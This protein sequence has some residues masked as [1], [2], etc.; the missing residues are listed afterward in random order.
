MKV[1]YHIIKVTK[2]TSSAC[3][4]TTTGSITNGTGT[5]QSET[6]GDSMGEISVYSNARCNGESPEYVQGDRKIA[7]TLKLEGAGIYCGNN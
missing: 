6:K 2:C 1:H 7:I 4:T 5:G 3:T